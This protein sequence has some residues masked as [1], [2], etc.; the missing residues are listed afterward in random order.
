MDTFMFHVMKASLR[1]PQSTKRIPTFSMYFR[2]QRSQFAN[3]NRTH[4][5]H[6]HRRSLFSCT[7]P[8][9]SLL[10]FTPGCHHVL[11]FSQLCSSSITALDSYY[12]E[13][14]F[15]VFSKV[16]LYQREEKKVTVFALYFL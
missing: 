16:L 1:H 3:S 9:A 6:C 5:E 14:Y 7:Y 13:R 12:R 2:H 11:T 15:K 4:A 8:V 10:H